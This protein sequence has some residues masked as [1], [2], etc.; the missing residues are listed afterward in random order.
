MG[1]P[2]PADPIRKRSQVQN[3]KR[4]LKDEG[5]IIEH[6]L[7]AI[8]VNSGLRV[9]DLLKLQVSDLWDE[10]GNPRKEFSMRTQKTGSLAY[11]QINQAIIE[12][13]NQASNVIN[14]YNPDAYL[15]ALRKNPLKRETVSRMVKRWCKQVGID[16]GNYSAHSL[17][18]T[19]AFH[20]WTQ[21]GKTF[22]ALAIVSKALGHKSTGTTMDY[23]GIRRA[24]VAE[25]QNDLNL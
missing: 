11:V 8:G 22:D 18:K 6:L 24:Q 7:F 14:I 21:H 23:L 19:F 4:L 17:R 15:F 2:N 16:S 13:M 25:W 20:M 1:I 12:V 10:D 5:K 3:I 9:G